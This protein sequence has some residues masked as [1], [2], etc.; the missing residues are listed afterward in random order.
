M[1]NKSLETELNKQQILPILNTTELRDDI[2]RLEV[3][4]LNNS[5]IKNIEITLRQEDS[6]EIAKEINKNFTN[7]N[8]GLGSILSE[9]DYLKGKDA[10]FHFFVSPGIVTSLVKNKVTNYIPGGETI[11][12]FIYLLDSGYKNIKFF[13]SN[14]AGGKKKLVAI[15]SILKEAIFIPTGGINKKNFMDYISL[16]NVLCVGMSKF[17]H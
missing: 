16:K 9:R 8:F 12:E 15:E 5:N 10:G 11:S 17:D 14:L 4:L 6:F 7:I 13:P 3:F 1:L 2:K